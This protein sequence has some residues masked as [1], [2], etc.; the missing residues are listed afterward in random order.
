MTDR[1]AFVQASWHSDILD[2][3]YDAFIAELEHQGVD[4]TRVDRVRV[5]GAFEIPLQLKLLAKS[6]R[7]AALVAAGWIVDAGVYRHEFVATAVINALMSI[8][9]ETEV[10][11]LSLVLTP[12]HFHSHDDHKGFFRDHFVLK[13]AEAARAC[14]GAIDGVAKA[15]ALA[16]GTL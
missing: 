16:A 9:L 7:Y 13:G 11:V 6:G 5:A 1:I 8:Q 2:G 3:G 15:K 10:P 4:P 12:H 14:L